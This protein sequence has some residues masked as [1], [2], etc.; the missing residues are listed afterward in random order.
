MQAL[1]TLSRNDQIRS[2]QYGETYAEENDLPK[3]G[4]AVSEE[5]YW[6]KYYNHPGEYVYEWSNGH[7]E[8]KPMSDVKGSKTCRWFCGILECYF[9]TYPVGTMVNLEIGFRIDI[10][11]KKGVRIPDI[12]VVL[13]DNPVCIYPNDCRYDGVFDMCVESL[14]Y[15][16]QTEIDRD[17]EEKRTEYE[18]MGVREY[19]ILDARG[20]ETVFYRLNSAGH[21]E[22]FGPMK[23]NNIIRSEVL[24]GFQFRISDLYRCPPFEELAE[25]KVYHTYVFPSYKKVRQQAELERLR[26]E[27]AEKQML[28]EK[29]R[30]EQEKQRAEQA[31]KQMLLEKQ[32]A[33]QEKQ[34]AENAEKQAQN[35]V[36]QFMETARAMLSNGLDTA[37]VM[38]YTGLSADEI[39]VLRSEI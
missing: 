24:P 8:V 30:A 31:E 6:E 35:A 14:S 9:Q 38:R 28:S 21:Y 26:A 1:Q 12:S 37:A 36:K 4:L 23:K 39:A 32:R 5:E 10:P 7:L 11:D 20:F 27:Q 34:R 33:E 19:Y 15:S 3:D 18:G 16:S 2:G 22:I 17:V 29:Q 13:N 25:D